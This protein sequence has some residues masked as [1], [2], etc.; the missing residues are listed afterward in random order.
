M[1]KSGYG[2]IECLV[3]RNGGREVTGG[4]Y[5]AKVGW[6]GGRRG[7]GAGAEKNVH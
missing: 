6:V 7:G 3:Y 5:R 4:V 1:G 2:Y